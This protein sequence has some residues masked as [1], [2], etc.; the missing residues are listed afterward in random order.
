MQSYRL[1]TSGFAMKDAVY[2]HTLLLSPFHISLPLFFYTA[3]FSSG[4]L[5]SVLQSNL[6]LPGTRLNLLKVFQSLAEGR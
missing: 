3:D 4:N 6:W 2:P 1:S 5:V